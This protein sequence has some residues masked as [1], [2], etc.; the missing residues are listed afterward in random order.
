MPFNKQNQTPLDIALSCTMTTK[1]EKLVKDLCSIDSFGKRDFEVK[2]KYE[3]MHNPN[4][5]T[6]TGVKM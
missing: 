3:Y 5:K 1:K 4:A 2:R 6:G